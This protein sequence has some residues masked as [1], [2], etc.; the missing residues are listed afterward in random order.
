MANFYSL[1]ILLR[2]MFACVSINNKKMRNNVIIMQ[3]SRRRT[4][5]YLQERG[6][7]CSRQTEITA[8]G[9]GLAAYMHNS[10]NMAEKEFV[11]TLNENEMKKLYL[12]FFSFLTHRNNFFSNFAWL[13]SFGSWGY[14]MPLCN[15]LR[16]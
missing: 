9:F 15:I 6:Y 14:I 7:W 8:S 3:C 16:A 4:Y 13:F 12:L 11:M 2:L 1:L 10:S 5:L